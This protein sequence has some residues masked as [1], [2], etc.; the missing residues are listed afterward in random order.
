MA[1]ALAALL[2]PACAVRAP[3]VPAGDVPASASWPTLRQGLARERASL[4]D[5]PWAAGLRATVAVPRQGRTFEGRGAIA[6]APARAVRMVLVGPAGT[7]LL[8][9]WA[10][11][12]AW[13]IAVPPADLVRRGGPEDPPGLPIGF[14]RWR[15]L[16]PYEGTLFGGALAPSEVTWLLRDGDA[17]V[18]VRRS[19]ADVGAVLA[20]S[21]RRSGRTE[22]IVEQRRGDAPREGDRVSYRDDA[23]GIG[24]DLLVESIAPRPP[25][26]R[27]FSDP[28]AEGV[29]P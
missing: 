1:T 19:P 8:D 6:V 7:T 23:G 22:R 4:P 21:R 3:E 12:S 5:S 11:A 13:R 10:T 17:V 28:D 18:E 29:G 26:E 2:I 24:A 20:L 15:F 9:A 14:L 25:D 27:A 16:R